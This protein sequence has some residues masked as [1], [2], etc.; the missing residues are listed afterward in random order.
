MNYLSDQCKK[1]T[2]IL[3]QQQKT[4]QFGYQ[5]LAWKE[6]R[7][8]NQRTAWEICD[9]IFKSRIETLIKFTRKTSDTQ[10]IS[11]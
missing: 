6:K 10:K 1:N 3:K 7:Y 11:E 2:A 9:K 4:D 8:T 5:R